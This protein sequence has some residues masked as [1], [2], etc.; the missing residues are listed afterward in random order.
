MARQRSPRQPLDP[1]IAALAAQHARDP[2]ALL[3]ILQALQ[4]RHG[5]LTAQNIRDVARALQVPAMRVY[6]VATFYALLA[7]P[8]QAGVPLRLCDGPVCWLA[9]AAAV[10]DALTAEGGAAPLLR[11]SCL[12]LCDR[13]PAALAGAEPG[14]PLDPAGAAWLNEGARPTPGVSGAASSVYATPR[15][16]EMRVLLAHAGQIDPDSLDSARA[17]GAY[18]ALQQALAG[19]PEA[20][21]AEVEAAGLL[22][23][24]GAGFPVGR[25]WR[26]VAQAPARPHY[27]VANAD[28]SEPL[29]FKDRVLM[30]S[31]PHQLLEGMALAG[32][33][34]GADT[35]IIYIRGEYAAQAARLERAMAQADAAGV[36]RGSGFAFQ[37]HLH[38]GAGAYICGE[39]TALRESLEGKRGEPRLRPPYP[40]SA[41]YRGRPTLVSNVETFAAVPAIIAHGAAWYRAL[42]PAATPGTKLY[43]LLGHIRRPGL[44]E[45][46]FGLTLRQ[47]IED[48]GGGIR[49]GS[50]FHFALTGGAAGTIVPPAL[51]DV[52]LDYTSAARGVA[53]GAGGVLVCDESVSP[54]ALLRELLHFF[55]V[56]SCG[57]CTPCRV[58]TQEA[59]VILDRLATGQGRPGDVTALQRLAHVLQ[60]ASFCGLGQSAATP[61]QTALAAFPADFARAEGAQDDRASDD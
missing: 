36:L 14:G 37:L 57:K 6:G 11:A 20:V 21:I 23:R 33:A 16:G 10:R 39:E 61:I 50:R 17:L 46:P 26:M 7:L 18:Q 5:G 13:A 56:E 59:W 53:L 2:E 32:Y 60:T 25:K 51:L 15:H 19:P 30:D 27:V 40:P 4:A 12:G 1:E 49:P 22:G 29:I 55:A 52:P 47:F 34:V 42:S 24:G 45:A 3:P 8:P 44:V 41:G 58:G 54:V 38:R 9:G 28:E 35:G 31:D 48:F 43:T